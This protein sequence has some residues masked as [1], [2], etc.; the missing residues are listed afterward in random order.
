MMNN[1]LNSR[2]LA[3]SM[4]AALVGF[5]ASLAFAELEEMVVTACKRKESLQTAARF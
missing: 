1:G 2:V 4:A 5:D 3:V